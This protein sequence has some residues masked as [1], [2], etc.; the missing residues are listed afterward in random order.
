MPMISLLSR[1]SFCEAFQEARPA[2]RRVEGGTGLVGLLAEPFEVAMLEL[3]P[4]AAR[5][6]DEAN[7]DLGDEVGVVG[8][9]G[10]DLP[11]KQHARRRLPGEHFAPFA[12]RTVFA[13]LVPAAAGARLHHHG[14]LRR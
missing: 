12:V 9:L 3:D 4:G 13:D 11:C 1:Y 6:G 2:A 8:P 7:L 5:V 10:G 14:L